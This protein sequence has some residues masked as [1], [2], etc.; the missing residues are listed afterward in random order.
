MP[1]ITG[2]VFS[3]LI[4]GATAPGSQRAH[5]NMWGAS[6]PTNSKVPNVHSV[7]MWASVLET[8]CLYIQCNFQRTQRNV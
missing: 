2:N 3:I 6:A 8:K 4:I 7:T 1:R 5:H